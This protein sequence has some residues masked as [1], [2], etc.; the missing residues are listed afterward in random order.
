MVVSSYVR[1]DWSRVNPVPIAVDIPN[2]DGLSGKFPGVD[3]SFRVDASK[4]TLEF[5]DR[6]RAVVDEHFREDGENAV[7]SRV[8]DQCRFHPLSATWRVFTRLELNRRTRI[9]G[10]L[11]R[12][13]KSAG[14]RCSCETTLSSTRRT[15][16]THRARRPMLGP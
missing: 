4:P 11:Q 5:L 3:G 13:C 8:G 14:A 6:A 15:V 12:P 10:M 9:E 7:F 2:E 16:W 1:G